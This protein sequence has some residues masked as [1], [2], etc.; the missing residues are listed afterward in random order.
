[1][2]KINLKTA[3]LGQIEDEC[4]RCTSLTGEVTS[5][6]SGPDGVDTTITKRFLPYHSFASTSAIGF[7]TKVWPDA[8]PDCIAVLFGTEGESATWIY[9]YGLGW[10]LEEGV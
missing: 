10:N 3:T 6:L 8:G 4:D 5:K 9:V 7:L 1:M 2:S